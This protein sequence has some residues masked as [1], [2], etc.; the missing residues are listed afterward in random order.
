MIRSKIR[1]PI[2][3]AMAAR[4][5]LSQ[6]LLGLGVLAVEVED[7]VLAVEDTEVEPVGRVEHEL[8]QVVLLVDVVVQGDQQRAAGQDQRGHHA[9]QPDQLGDPEPDDV[10]GGLG[11]RRRGGATLGLL[12]GRR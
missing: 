11:L 6:R 12:L 2:S 1:P 3:Q 5:Q 7:A 4:P 8:D 10:G 9:D